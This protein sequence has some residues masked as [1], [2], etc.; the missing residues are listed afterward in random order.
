[1]DLS[2]KNKI[3]LPILLIAVFVFSS[4]GWIF[5]FHNYQ[6]KQIIETIQLL[7]RIDSDIKEFNRAIQSGILTLDHKYVIQSDG[8]SLRVFDNL[9]N[10]KKTHPEDA[11]KIKHEY[12]GYYSKLISINS[13]FLEKRLGE[14]RRRLTELESSYSR[15]NDEITKSIA[16][17]TGEYKRAVM[18]K[19]CCESS[20]QT[21]ERGFRGKRYIRSSTRFSAPSTKP[22]QVWVFP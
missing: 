6:L 22:A 9:N 3:I 5:Y 2:E 7:N 21:Q 4:F 18:K 19:P 16:A 17:H 1:M 8:H 12:M 10:L 20:L 11:D 15:I 14:G 13:L